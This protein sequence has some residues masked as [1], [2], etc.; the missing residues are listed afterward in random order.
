MLR[1]DETQEERG[2]AARALNAEDRN[3]TTEPS[4]TQVTR[5][6]QENPQRYVAEGLGA[7]E[8]RIARGLHR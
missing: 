1:M 5:Q 6:D 8:P 7:P 4:V 2:N 3:M